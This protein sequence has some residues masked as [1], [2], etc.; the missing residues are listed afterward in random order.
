MAAGRRGQVRAGEYAVAGGVL[1]WSFDQHG[2]C[3]VR[4]DEDLPNDPHASARDPHR[5]RQRLSVVF[6]HHASLRQAYAA[7][8]RGRVAPGGGG[9]E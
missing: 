6:V 5:L 2:A 4:V 3:D 8:Q 7:A 1:V 9:G